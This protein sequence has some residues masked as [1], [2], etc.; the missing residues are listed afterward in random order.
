MTDDKFK[1]NNWEKNE[2]NT[3]HTALHSKKERELN[4]LKQLSKFGAE[5]Q[6]EKNP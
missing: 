6:P 5:R 1:S 2:I 3:F 4:L